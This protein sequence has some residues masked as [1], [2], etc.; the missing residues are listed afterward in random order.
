MPNRILKESIC[1]SDSI[2]ELT[3]FE[4]VFFYRLIVNC[5]D[6]GR[7]DGRVAIIKANLFPLKNVTN[8]QVEQALNKLVTAGIVCRYTVNGKPYLQLLAWENHQTVRNQKSKYPSIDNADIESNCKQLKSIEINC[9]QLQANEINCNQL[10]TNDSPIQSNPIQSE[11]IS[12]Y[13][14]NILFG[15]KD[16]EQTSPTVIQLI[17][18]DK[19]F[20]PI[21]QEQV[22]HWKELFPNVN[23]LQQLR[24]MVSWLESNPT[25]RKTKRGILKF[26]NAWLSREQDKGGNKPINK[27]DTLHSDNFKHTS[28]EK[29]TQG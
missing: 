2:D 12:E 6:F 24:N 8:A 29:L 7:F 18:N 14:S 4:E 27:T 9:N 22:D 1:S 16:T 23:V 26:V 28:L 11:S 17:L 19:S 25:K 21:T 15:A 5:D 13:E 10:N 3:W 20:Y